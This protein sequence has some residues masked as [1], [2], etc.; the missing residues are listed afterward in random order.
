[1]N[2]MEA[3]AIGLAIAAV[4][5]V[6]VVI[7]EVVVPRMREKRKDDDE[8]GKHMV[9]GLLK[10]EASKFEK[11]ISTLE[12]HRVGVD[13]RLRRYESKVD[14]I[15]RTTGAIHTDVAVVKDAVQ[16]MRKDQ[17]KRNGD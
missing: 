15:A 3:T 11:R 12:E 8:E 6:V 17:K 4:G 13:A 1:M 9:G 16:W 14:E 5:L 2:G 10:C 7:K